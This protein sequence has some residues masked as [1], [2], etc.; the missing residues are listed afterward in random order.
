MYKLLTDK[1]IGNLDLYKKDRDDLYHKYFHDVEFIDIDNSKVIVCR[2]SQQND[3][4]ITNCILYYF[5]NITSI[6]NSFIGLDYEFVFNKIA[7]TQIGLYYED[8]TMIYIIDP[9]LLS[10][11]Q[12]EFY[13][14]TLY[15]SPINRIVHGSDSL[16]IPYIFTKLF[17]ND[18]QK[19]IK[20]TDMLIDTRYLCEYYKIYIKENNIKCSLY[21]GL[22]YFKTI[23]KDLY[24][25][26]NSNMDDIHYNRKDEWNIHKLSDKHIKYTAYDVIFLKDFLQNIISEADKVDKHLTINIIPSLTRLVYYIKWNII[27]SY[28]EIKNIN[29]SMNNNFIYIRKKKLTLN[30]IFNSYINTC[31]IGNN[32]KVADFLNI[33]YFKT[34]ILNI[35]K[36]FVYEYIVLNYRVYVS[37]NILCDNKYNNNL[38]NNI[39]KL[40]IKKLDNFFNLFSKTIKNELKSFIIK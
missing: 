22:Y 9:N 6:I 34:I 1:Y 40:N 28:D 25:Y 17:N 14:N 7:L 39:N 5:D 16:D 31:V 30:Q 23:N 18:T 27:Q 10:E 11:E 21:D 13:I 3:M 29:D 24:D 19:I 20:F 4:F 35:F 12:L 37:K 26:L 2:T 36:A 15:I 32:I 8:K 33:N 38:I